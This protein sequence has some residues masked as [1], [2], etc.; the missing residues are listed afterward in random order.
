[1]S[2]HIIKSGGYGYAIWL[3]VTNNDVFTH[4]NHNMLHCS[5]MVLMDNENAKALNDELNKEF[6]EPISFSVVRKVTMGKTYHSN[7]KQVS[8]AYEVEYK[9]KKIQERVKNICMKYETKGQYVEAM[10]V[11]LYYLPITMFP[12]ILEELSKSIPETCEVFQ[13]RFFCVDTVSPYHNDWK[14][15]SD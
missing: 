8:L 5:V 7:E 3:K 12:V 15:I 2:S 6:Q 13:T 11:S 1:M 14:V 9:D 10:H 4:T